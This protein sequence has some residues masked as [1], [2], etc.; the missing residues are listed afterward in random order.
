MKR[1]LRGSRGE[2][3]Q[4]QSRACFVMTGGRGMVELTGPVALGL[5]PK[6]M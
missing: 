3:M 2:K 5:V 6:T 4:G 1:T